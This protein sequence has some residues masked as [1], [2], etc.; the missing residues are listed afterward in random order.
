MASKLTPQSALAE[1]LPHARRLYEVDRR[2]SDVCA[3][4]GRFDNNAATIYY[5]STDRSAAHA[6][7]TKLARNCPLQFV[8]LACVVQ[9]DASALP[10]EFQVI[11]VT[12]A[13]ITLRTADIVISENGGEPPLIGGLGDVVPLAGA[14]DYYESVKLLLHPE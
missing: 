1:L 5:L 9:G 11:E 10:S 6:Q 3:V 4:A 2:F 12:I 8:T 7:I 13:G 14:A